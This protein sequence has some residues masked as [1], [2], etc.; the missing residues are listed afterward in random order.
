DLRNR[1]DWKLLR[2]LAEERPDW[3]ILLIG[4]GRG[5]EET[6]ALAG[7]ENVKFLGT[8]PYAELD[9]WLAL[10][11]VAIVPHMV[12]RIS[13]HMNPLKVYAYL[14]A[15]LPVV[16]T[17]VGNLEGVE[18]LVRIADGPKA[19]I[20]AVEEALEADRPSKASRAALLSRIGWPGR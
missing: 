11:D 5:T 7:L 4:P 17:G 15:G 20:S 8:I 18:D 13:R 10:F 1:I 16:S 3:T 14:A 6:A 9:R 12:N 19:F 2:S